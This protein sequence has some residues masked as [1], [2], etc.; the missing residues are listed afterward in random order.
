MS[1]ARTAHRSPTEL[2]CMCLPQVHEWCTHS[3]QVP[4]SASTCGA[5]E[6]GPQLRLSLASSCRAVLC[7]RAQ[8]P[9]SQ[10]LERVSLFGRHLL[11]AAITV[12][13]QH[14]KVALSKLKVEMNVCTNVCVCACV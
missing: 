12:E 4:N 10:R 2:P 13:M 9:N 6:Q 7:A 14:G 5:H 8:V 11:Q 1:G 3:T